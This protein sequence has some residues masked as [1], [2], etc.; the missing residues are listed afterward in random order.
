[1]RG[2]S[3]SCL[4]T[5]RPRRGAIGPVRCPPE[6]IHRFQVQA[7]VYV[8]PLKGAPPPPPPPPPLKGAGGGAANGGG[9]VGGGGAAVNG[10]D[11][12]GGGVG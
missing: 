2:T 3:A 12:G 5:P 8:I 1:M 11:V 9:I 10:A 4:S 6:Y 7:I